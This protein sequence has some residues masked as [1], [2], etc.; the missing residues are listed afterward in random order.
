MKTEI[1]SIGGVSIEYQFLRRGTETVLAFLHEGLGCAKMWKDFPAALS[2]RVGLSSFIY[3]RPG[4]GGSSPV[5]LPRPGDYMQR[6]G[7]IGLAAVLDH[8]NIENV[9]LFGHSDGASIAL[10]AAAGQLR[11]RIRGLIALAPHVVIEDIT[12]SAIAELAR[13]FERNDVK[14][15]MTRYHGSNTDCAF[16][17]FANT[18]LTEQNARSWTIESLLPR[19]SCP[20]LLVQGEQDAFGTRHQIDLIKAGVAG[21]VEALMLPS[22]GPWPHIDKRDL[23]IERS[24]DFIRSLVDQTLKTVTA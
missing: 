20:V 6:E 21:H 23:V 24:A 14:S 13:N 18:W 16:W 15:K 9:I 2:S 4:Y 8:F 17:G 12:V 1:A 22:C 7:L 5:E 3:S 10:I 11:Q 19:I